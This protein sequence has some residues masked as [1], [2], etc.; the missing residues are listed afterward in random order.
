MKSYT[1]SVKLELGTIEYE[2]L[3][4]WMMMAAALMDFELGSV[5]VALVGRLKHEQTNPGDK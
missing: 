2:A 1:V 5:R 4:E 3:T